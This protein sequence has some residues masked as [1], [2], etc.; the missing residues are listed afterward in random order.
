MSPNNGLTLGGSSEG[1]FGCHRVRLYCVA[2]TPVWLNSSHGASRTS[3]IDEA[4]VMM[5]TGTSVK[6]TKLD[7][8]CSRRFYLFTQSW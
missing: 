5:T 7:W 2:M 8:P 3:L 1:N 6:A 4:Q